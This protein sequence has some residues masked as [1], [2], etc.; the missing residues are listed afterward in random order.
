M[1]AGHS[2]GVFNYADYFFNCGLM[3]V[4]AENYREFWKTF[5]LNFQTKKKQKFKIPMGSP[6]SCRNTWPRTP[7][8]IYIKTGGH[9]IADHNCEASNYDHYFFN[10]RLMSVLGQN[11]WEFWKTFSQNF[12]TKNKL[13]FEIPMGAPNPTNRIS[14]P[15]KQIF[16]KIF[17]STKNFVLYRLASESEFKQ[18]YTPWT[19]LQTFRNEAL[20][21]FLFSK[22]WRKVWKKIFFHPKNPYRDSL[23]G[24][25]NHTNNY[26][27][28]HFYWP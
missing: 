13:K 17:F 19:P 16:L 12:L 6:K 25:R 24:L 7:L 11:Y 9:M 10:C 8:I 18:F 23:G 14:G 26:R 22:F 27:T 15:K 1:I 4:L 28:C 5:S 21:F 20:S 2:Y 3:S